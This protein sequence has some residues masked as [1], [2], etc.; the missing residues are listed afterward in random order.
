MHFVFAEAFELIVDFKS[1]GKCFKPE[2]RLE[3]VRLVADISPMHYTT[4][5][6]LP[7]LDSH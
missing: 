3:H 4:C 5:E 6:T 7:S 2:Q 1:Y